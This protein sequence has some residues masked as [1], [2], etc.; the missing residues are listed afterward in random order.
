MRLSLT[1]LVCTS[2]LAACASPY[3]NFIKS[4]PTSLND[5][6]VADTVKQLVA[7]YQPASTHFEID[8]STS[9]GYGNALVK[10]LRAKGYAVKAVEPTFIETHETIAGAL[11]L[12]YVL[13]APAN[14]YRL[15]VSVDHK[16]ITRAYVEQ[17]NM[18]IPA[19][20]WIQKEQ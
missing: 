14:L 20:A 5:K 7:L 17:N 16:T 4:A 1:I 11:R 19:G 3:G 15:T 6:L 9:D 12:R 2:M 10:Q 18:I 8:Q 13:D